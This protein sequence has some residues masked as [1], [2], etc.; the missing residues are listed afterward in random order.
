[1]SS[2][3][4]LER[5]SQDPDEVVMELR[6][7]E[8]VQINLEGPSWSDVVNVIMPTVRDHP[9]AGLTL[10]SVSDA[11][12]TS[13]ID[14]V[15][16]GWT[17]ADVDDEMVMRIIEVLRKLDLSTVVGGVARLIASGSHGSSGVTPW[18]RSSEAREFAVYL[19]EQIDPDAIGNVLSGNALDRAIGHPA[20]QIALFWIRSIAAEWDRSTAEAQDAEEGWTGLSPLLQGS[21]ETLL[22]AE[23]GRS[24]MVEVIFASQLIFFFAVDR[25]WCRLHVLPLLDWDDPDRAL[26]NWEGFLTWGRWGNELLEDGLRER[27]EATF[28]HVGDFSDQ[29]QTGFCNHL[30]GIAVYADDDPVPLLEAFTAS[31]PPAICAQWMVQ[32]SAVLRQISAEAVEQQWHRWMRAY[33]QHRLSGVPRTLTKEESAALALWV[34]YLTESVEEAVELALQYESAVAE[35]SQ[36]LWLLDGEKLDKAPVAY[37]R[38]IAHCLDGTSP[39]FWTSYHL[40]PIVER[41]RTLQVPEA[42][43]EAIKEAAIRLQVVDAGSW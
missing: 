5:I 20:G 21:L 7:F 38:L 13:F 9:A 30:A 29:F 8:N 23:D 19:W 36:F 41:L 42:E 40:Q 10:L 22:G 2:A 34:V 17:D 11:Q 33:W 16:W 14:A 31:V 12:S 4:L 32:V 27:Y 24:A 3:Q 37:A 39:P 35:H 6:R 26:R 15:V 25:E 28:E 1:M 18:H 43:I